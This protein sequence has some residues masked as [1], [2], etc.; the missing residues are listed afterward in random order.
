MFDINF[1]GRPLQPSNFL[2]TCKNCGAPRL[3][4][5]SKCMARVVAH[6]HMRLLHI[7]RSSQ[8]VEHWLLDLVATLL[9]QTLKR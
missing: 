5:N 8:K 9:V 7:E 1:A 3:V 6:T 4:I 2:N